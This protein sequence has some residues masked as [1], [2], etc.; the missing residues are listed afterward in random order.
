MSYAAITYR[1]RPGH[2]EEIEKIF[3]DF[4]RAD[5]PVLRDAQGTP[6]GLL[7]GTALFIK[8]DVMVR[9]VHYD[10]NLADV[11]RHMSIQDGVHEAERRLAPFLAQPRDTETPEG[12][13]THFTGATMRCVQQFALP[14][15]AAQA[16]RPAGTGAP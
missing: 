4:R 11:A 1:V 12:F 2:E 13:I 16:L 10:G 3:A 8:D 7:L 14:P 6:T 15:E 5:S 9:L